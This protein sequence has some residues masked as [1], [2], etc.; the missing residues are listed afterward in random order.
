MTL[1]NAR[2]T[3][4]LNATAT[5]ISTGVSGSVRIGDASASLSFADANVAYAVRG[6]FAGSGDVMDIVLTTGVTSASTAW[7]AGIAQVETAT[8]TAVG[9]ITS[10]GT[11]SITVTAAGMTGSPKS[12]S[13]A[14][15]IA[16]HTTA[17][18]IATAIAA[19]LNADTAYAAMF[20]ATSSGATVITTRKPT[21]DFTVPGGTLELYAAN[22]ATLNIAIPSGLGITAAGTSVN[23]TAGV[24]S[25]GVKIYDNA[26]D[27]EGAALPTLA[28]VNGLMVKNN[29][30]GTVTSGATDDYP[31]PAGSTA[32]FAGPASIQLATNPNFTASGVTD[33]TITVIGQTA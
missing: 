1:T 3:F 10:D 8:V 13:V 29:G 23:T 12:I 19:A 28:T 9:G 4:G 17:T 5:P 11:A 21:R 24:I 15:T 30:A 20:T 14:L 18:L 22:D 16:T 33:I 6:I 27:F 2:A 31:V 25:D 32:L 26:T 7:V